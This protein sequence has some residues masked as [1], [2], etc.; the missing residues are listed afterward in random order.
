MRLI[1][2]LLLAI[3]SPMMVALANVDLQVLSPSALIEQ[4]LDRGYTVH[5]DVVKKNQVLSS[6]LSDCSVDYP[7]IHKLVESSKDIFNIRTMKAG[8]PYTVL[9]DAESGDARLLLYEHNPIDW[10]VFSV[11]ENDI[12]T[13]VFQKPV[14]IVEREAA[15]IITTSLSA[16]MSELGI[17]YELTDRLSEVYAWSID[18]WRIQYGDRFRVIYEEKLVDGKS[19]GIAGV[20]AASFRHYDGDF[21][22]FRYATPEDTLGMSY[23]DEKGGSM[24]KQF[25]RAPVKYS[26]ISSRYSR[27]RFHPVQK[28]W[29]AHLGTDYAAPKG[30]PIYATA[31]GIITEAR[32]KR[33]NGNYVKIR[34]NGTYSTQYLHMTKIKKGIRS[35]VKVRQGQVIGFVGSTGLATGPHVCYR[36]WKNGKQVDALKQKFPATKPIDQQYYPDFMGYKDQLMERLE[37]V[38][39]PGSEF[40][41]DEVDEMEVLER[42]EE[43]E[44]D[45]KL[46][47][48][49]PANPGNWGLILA[50]IV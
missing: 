47:S 10:V 38:P 19:V 45:A 3:I 7:R 20:K 32:F 23:F 15:G 34:H 1:T 49:F 29:K 9:C 33:A 27:R 42:L 18:F 22:A 26:R 5:E 25:L 24:Q 43:Q 4:N 44:S 11:E 46:S 17:N 14:E 12:S 31:D 8:R 21:Y 16:T 6:M 50:A 13:K 36:F 40:E 41:G 2:C 37:S 48:S 30:T 39:Y 35:G 28:R